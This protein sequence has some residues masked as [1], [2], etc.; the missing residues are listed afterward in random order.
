MSETRETAP[1]RAPHLSR[2]LQAPAYPPGRTRPEKPVSFNRTKVLFRYI[3]PTIK[4]DPKTGAYYALQV[5]AYEPN[6]PYGPLMI[7]IVRIQPPEARVVGQGPLA[8]SHYDPI[9][10]PVILAAIA[11]AGAF[12]HPE[13]KGPIALLLEAKKYVSHIWKRGVQRWMK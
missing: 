9:A 7:S 8:V 1:S 5:E 6:E 2:V 10:T 13:G 3:I 4:R 11:V 12:H